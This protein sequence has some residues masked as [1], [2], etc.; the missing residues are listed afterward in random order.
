MIS[1]LQKILTAL[2]QNQEKEPEAKV[3]SQGVHHPETLVALPVC[4]LPCL[5]ITD[6]L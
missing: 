4:Y 2:L 1:H 6:L 5:Q 3:L